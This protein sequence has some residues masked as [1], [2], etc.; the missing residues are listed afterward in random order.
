MRRKNTVTEKMGERDVRKRGVDVEGWEMRVL[1]EV[2]R[3][4]WWDSIRYGRNGDL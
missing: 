1:K 4:G 2:R 3:G